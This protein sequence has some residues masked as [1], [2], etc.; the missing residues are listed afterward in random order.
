MGNVLEDITSLDG[1]CAQCGLVLPERGPS[2]CPQ[3]GGPY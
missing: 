3:C 1:T 2:M